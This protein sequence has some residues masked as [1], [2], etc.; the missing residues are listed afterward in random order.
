M[1]FKK[2]KGSFILECVR[3]YYILYVFEIIF[4]IYLNMLC[5]IN[6]FKHVILALF[7]KTEKKT[8]RRDSFYLFIYFVSRL[9]TGFSWPEQ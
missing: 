5:F 9:L 8:K 7:S 6:I 2:A 3:K 1:I 4:L